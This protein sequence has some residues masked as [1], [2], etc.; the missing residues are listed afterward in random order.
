MSQLLLIA[1]AVLLSGAI[2]LAFRSSVSGVAFSYL[3]LS[4]LR[5][6]KYISLNNN[7]MLFWALAVLI[8]LIINFWRGRKPN[9]PSVCRNYIV[10][11]ALVGMIVGLVMGYAG[12]IIGSAIGAMLGGIAWS[13]TASGNAV[14]TRIWRSIVE[15]GLPAV[16]TMSVVGMALNSLIYT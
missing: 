4:A 7:L 10:G 12:M 6:S 13:R 1:G 11:G 8:V 5:G 9:V 16:V 2:V 14:T 15:I 3:G